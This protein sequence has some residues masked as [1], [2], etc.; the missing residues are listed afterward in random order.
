MLLHAFVLPGPSLYLECSYLN[1]LYLMNFS[2][3]NILDIFIAEISTCLLFWNFNDY[4]LRE[5]FDEYGCYIL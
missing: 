2:S 3:F 4:S 1:I 5:V